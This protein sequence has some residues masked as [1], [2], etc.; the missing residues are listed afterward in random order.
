M[1]ELSMDNGRIERLNRTIRE[2]VLDFW[3]FDSLRSLNDELDRWRTRYNESHPHTSLNGLS[4]RAFA[5]K[6]SVEVASE[7]S[8]SLAT[9]TL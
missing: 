9:S 2:D 8:G 5:S 1:F 4:P 6:R 3:A 7:P